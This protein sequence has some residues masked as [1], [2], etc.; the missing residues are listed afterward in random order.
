MFTRFVALRYLRP[1]KNNL[2]VSM[3][4][5]ISIVGVTVGVGAI[6]FV[7]S[8]LNGFEREVRS[9]FVGFDAHLRISAANGDPLP[10]ADSVLTM[11][12][13]DRRIVATAPFI[14][15]KAMITSSFGSHVAFVKGTVEPDLAAVTDLPQN[16]VGGA[17]DFASHDGGFH[18]SLI[19]YS[20]GVQLDLDESD[21]LT[22]I[23]PAGV[24]SPFSQPM[25]R[26]F[27]V[28]GS[29]KTDMFEY[30]NAYV[31][32]GLRE[33]QELFEV[34]GMHGVEIRMHH[35]E[36][37]F[38]MAQE[39]SAVL[40]DRYLV[41]TWH[42]R[43]ADLYKAMAMEKWGSL[44][45]LSLIIM[46]AGFNIVS[47]LIMGVMQKT[48]EIGILKAVG[49]SSKMISGIF[50]RQGLVVGVLGIASGCVIGYG[51]CFAQVWFGWIPLPSDIFFL[52]TL[53]M[54]IQGMDF[55]AIVAV[56]FFLCLA[57]TVYPA[58]KAASLAPIQALRSV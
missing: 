25:A 50:V 41:E 7:L 8:M 57:S 13:Q 18:G 2:F 58:R 23:S 49:A 27:V 33:A 28:S 1:Q 45:L 34:D 24:T 22:M 15:E 26:R 56:A 32:I 17:I 51:V 29:F 16:M 11:L 3:I 48:S 43:H 39:L 47:T 19:G 54:E 52:D 38:A 4:G 12:K 5:L 31:F 30:D 37:A 35:L 9:R 20:L 14:L 36:E 21:T 10:A 42:D 6:V 44:I 46:V 55:L 40:G 53:P